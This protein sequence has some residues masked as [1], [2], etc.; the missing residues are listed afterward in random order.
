MNEK[1]DIPTQTLR[2]FH[3]LVVVLSIFLTL[4][5][6]Y[7]SKKQIDEKV[8]NQFTREASQVVELISE[9]MQKYEDG[10]WGGVAAIQAKGGN[11]SYRDWFTFANSLHLEGKYPGING[12]GVIHHVS[13]KGLNAYLKEQRLDRPNYKIHPKHNE[14]EFFPITYIEPVKTNVKAVG[15]DM[16]Y[17]IN[18]YTASKKSRDTGVAQITGPIALVQDEAKTPGFLFFAPFYK[19]GTHDSLKERKN[20][21]TGMVYAPFVMKKLMKGVL[22]KGKR[23]VGIRIKDGDDNLYNELVETNIDFDDHPLF[24]KNFEIDLY[25]RTWIFDIQSAKSFREVSKNNQPLMILFGGIIIDSLLL[26]LFVFLARSNKKAVT[27]AELINRELK[28]KTQNLEESNINLAQAKLEAENANQAKSIFLANMSHE[29]RTPM[30]AILGY[31]QVLLRRSGL[32][33]NQKEAIETIDSSGK[34]L[35]NLI[36]EILDISK[37]E[38]GHMELHPINFNFNELINEISRMF[39]LQ[40]REKDLLLDFQYSRDSHL[41]YGDENKIRQI[42]VNIIGNSVKFT[43]S[44]KI[45]LRVTPIANNKFKFEIS[46]TGNGIPDEVKK[47]IFDPF[48]QDIQGAQKGGTGLGLAICKKQIELMGGTLNFESKVGKGSRFY[49]DLYLPDATG[50]IHEQLDRRKV[51]HLAEGFSVKALIVDDVKEN[52]DVL[53]G[54]LDDIGVEIL[55]ASNGKEAIEKVEE[56]A[57]E[58]IFMDMKMPLMRGEEAVKIIR[59]KYGSEKIKIVAITASIFENRS[60]VYCEMGCDYFLSKPFRVEQIFNSLKQLLGVE[61]EY[62]TEKE[63]DVLSKSNMNLSNITIPKILYE[64]F[65]SSIEL[66]NIT[67][68]EINLGKLGE[69]NEGCKQVKEILTVFMKNYDMNGFRNTL[70]KLKVEE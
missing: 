17:E 20:N 52:Q 51:I 43:D 18:R 69:I 21:F 16:A 48:T 8:K 19:G 42:L 57:P 3:W 24:K 36:N 30:N 55:L 49:F 14:N 9:R 23:R 67:T 34:N 66:C 26:A 25:G 59:Q 44:G 62:E 68:L 32:D 70:E 33:K 47:S 2:W 31:T 10:L 4:F 37:I 56:S 11:I 38:A 64:D 13:K 39:D 65:L 6:W 35:L 54:L 12:I 1:N 50:E 53:V 63:E 40:C 58:I 15:L 27:Y 7:F 5:A 41:V 28:D 29:I 22:E 46:D 61:F 60:K 45:S